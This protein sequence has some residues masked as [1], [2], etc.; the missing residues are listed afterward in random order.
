[1]ITRND[2]IQLIHHKRALFSDGAMG[3]VLSQR[4]PINQTCLD[5]V[6]LTQPEIVESVHHDYLLAGS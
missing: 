5:C 3:T 1:M 4:L 2:L 6:N